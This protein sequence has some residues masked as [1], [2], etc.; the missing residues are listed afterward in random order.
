MSTI[1]IAMKF[2]DW[3]LSL[4]GI[5]VG[6]VTSLRELRGEYRELHPDIFPSPEFTIN[7]SL[8][9]LS[10]SSFS[11]E[12]LPELRLR[13][14]PPYQSTVRISSDLIEHVNTS[15]CIGGY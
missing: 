8:K 12:P 4:I 9:L 14:F 2:M 6:Y 5:S 1:V 3:E 15:D 11:R 13:F 10:G 7:P